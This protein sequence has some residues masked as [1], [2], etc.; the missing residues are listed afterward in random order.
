MVLPYSSYSKLDVTTAHRTL[1]FEILGKDSDNWQQGN[2]Q[3]LQGIIHNRGESSDITT[4]GWVQLCIS[5]P[6]VYRGQYREVKGR[7]FDM[8]HLQCP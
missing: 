3:V 8:N 6:G 4:C 2:R 7:V 5:H 1:R